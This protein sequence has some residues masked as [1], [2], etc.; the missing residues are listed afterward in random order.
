MGLWDAEFR[1]QQAYFWTVWGLQTHVSHL[2]CFRLRADPH[3]HRKRH[4]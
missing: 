2:E 4:F 3:C 1:P